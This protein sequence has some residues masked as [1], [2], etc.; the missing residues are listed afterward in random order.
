MSVFMK[1][2]Y[3]L[4]CM[5]M[6]IRK[7]IWNWWIDAIEGEWDIKVEALSAMANALGLHNQ[8]ESSWFK[9]IPKE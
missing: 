5:K 7:N 2:K 9:S 6:S 3:V 4:N 1:K 8:L